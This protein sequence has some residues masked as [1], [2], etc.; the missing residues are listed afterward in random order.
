[1]KA[2]GFDQVHCDAAGH[3]GSMRSASQAKIERP[4]RPAGDMA[5]IGREMNTLLDE[6]PFGIIDELFLSG[7]WLLR[8]KRSK[9]RDS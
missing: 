5:R 2:A 8:E 7:V 4:Q 3:P 6:L 1:M 9:S